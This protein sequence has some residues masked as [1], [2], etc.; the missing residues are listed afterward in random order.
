METRETA[1]M[2]AAEWIARRER[3]DW[4]DADQVELDAW[5]RADTSHRVAW[6]RA[7][8]AWQQ[9][10]RLKMLLSTAAPG[11]VPAPEELRL[12]FAEISNECKENALADVSSDTPK[13]AKLISVVAACVALAVA[14]TA[15]YLT[16]RST[17]HH[18]EIGALRT[19]PLTDGSRVT[20]NTN[21]ALRVGVTQT[22]RR[23]EL[24]QGEAYFDVARD[25]LR[26][27]VVEA[28]KSRVIAIGTRFSVRRDGE[29]V[30]VMV[31]EGR[32]RIERRPGGGGPAVG[33]MAAT[34]LAAGSMA[35]ARADDILVLDRTIDDVEQQLSWRVGRL[36]FDNTPLAEAAAEFNRYNTRRIHIEDAS[37]GAIRVGGN[38]SASNV[39]GFLRLV[40]SDF[41]VSITHR[42]NDIYVAEAAPR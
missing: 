17:R 41:P 39:E 23:I 36:T 14:G 21:T 22:E 30:R 24:E 8:A 40:A 29:E 37:V 20:L 2:A 7:S 38:F 3:D 34:E 27:F 25:P 33:D 28:G 16:P 13:R 18:T 9:T 12:P 6:L 42:G 1:E 4:S 19:V 31:S 5:I 11:A 32:V 15:S 26:P 10:D 35:H